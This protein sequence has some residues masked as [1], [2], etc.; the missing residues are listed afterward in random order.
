MIMA[1][2]EKK[3][4]HWPAMGLG[5]VVATIF[6]VVF[7]TFEVDETEHAVLMIL[8]KAK[9]ETVNGKKVAK[10]YQPGLHL[11]APYPFGKVWTQDKRLQCYELEKGKV[12]QVQTKDDYQII[13]TTYV[14]WKVGDPVLYMKRINTVKT[15]EN[16]L[17]ELVR[18]SR[19]S[20]LGR[21]ELGELINV[22]PEKGRIHEI[23]DEIL[24]A[25]G[26]EAIDKYGIN[27]EFLGFKHLGFPEKVSSKVFERMKAERQRK[28]EEYRAEGKRDAEKIRA[29]ADLKVSQITAKAEAESK[30]IRAE[31]DKAAAE[32]YAV[33]REKPELA[34]FLRKLESLRKTLSEKTTLVLDTQTP[35]YD[36]FLPQALEIENKKD[37]NTQTKAGTSKPGDN[38]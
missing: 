24:A 31:G 35:P 18:N 34:V 1:E 21:H 19:N 26:Q 29:E 38:E 4:R 9:T 13:V 12:E 20:V 11:R 33:F 23:E 27:V 17:D 15:A 14:L 2:K 30:R 10:V 5:I 37:N 7:I 6:V 32:H 25:L 8:G 16:K 36:L 3:N 28:S 22:D